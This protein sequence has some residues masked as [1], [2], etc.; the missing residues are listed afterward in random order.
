LSVDVYLLPVFIAEQI[1]KHIMVS[2]LI[3][4]YYY[5]VV[6]CNYAKVCYGLTIAKIDDD[7]SSMI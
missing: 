6:D 5:P 1:L 3:Y 4:Y 7:C 2:V